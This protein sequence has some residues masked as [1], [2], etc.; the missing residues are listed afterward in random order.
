MLPVKFQNVFE[1]LSEFVTHEGV[2]NWI[3][4]AVGQ[5]QDCADVVHDPNV[6]H[7]REVHENRNKTKNMEWKHGHG[8][9]NNNWYKD[10]QRFCVCIVELFLFGAFVAATHIMHFSVQQFAGANFAG[11]LPVRPQYQDQRKDVPEDRE[12]EDIEGESPGIGPTR[13]AVDSPILFVFDEF[14]HKVQRYYH[15]QETCKPD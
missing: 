5:Q 7:F 11:D 12:R 15:N 3:G 1:A 14:H 2:Y 9:H 6:L 13:R 10:L 8:K 4:S